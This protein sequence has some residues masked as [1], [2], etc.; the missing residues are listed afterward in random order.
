MGIIEIDFKSLED[1]F[2]NSASS[3]SFN[4]KTWESSISGCSSHF[5]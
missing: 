2:V 5:C 4:Q 3:L 1:E